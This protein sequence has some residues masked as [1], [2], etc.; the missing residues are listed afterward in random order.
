VGSDQG[1]RVAET[2]PGVGIGVC[3]T[4]PATRQRVC[5]AL[6]PC[7][8]SVVAR[9]ATLGGLLARCGESTPACVVLGA[10][11]P[12]RATAGAAASI[13]SELR[14]ARIVLV[15]R[16]ARDGDVRRALG[17]GVEGVVLLERIEEALAA[18]VS[19]V[20]SGQISVPSQR[21]GEVGAQVLT[22]R[23]KQILGL[24]VMGLTNAQI[25]AKVYLAESTVKSH[26]S[27]AFSKLDVSSR[28]EAVSLILD[29]ERGRGLGILTIPAARIPSPA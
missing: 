29:P 8:Q 22:T 6:A 27:S 2:D 4:E 26:L 13:R 17:F 28:Y 20:C 15:C 1:I 12:N 14:A 23:E 5:A 21:R 10:E 16:R 11:R 7:R 3:V 18:V 9:E 25:A 19:V 24:V